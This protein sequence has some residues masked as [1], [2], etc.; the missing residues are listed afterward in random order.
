MRRSLLLSQDDPTIFFTRPISAVFLIMAVLMAITS[1][2]KFK[3]L[4]EIEKSI[5]ENENS[6][7]IQAS[8]K[9]KNNA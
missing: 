8:I 5:A 7:A 1:Y 6:E 4:R 3:K 9:N 2:R